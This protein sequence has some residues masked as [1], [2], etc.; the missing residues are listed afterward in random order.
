MEKVQAW[1][2]LTVSHLQLFGVKGGVETVNKRLVEWKQKHQANAICESLDKQVATLKLDSE[3][4]KC[5]YTLCLG[6]GW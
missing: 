6:L 4:G 1:R 5:A 3:K 2:L